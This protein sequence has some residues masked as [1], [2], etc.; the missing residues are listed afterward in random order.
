MKCVICGR[1]KSFETEGRIIDGTWY[2]DILV[3]KELHGKWVCCYRCYRDLVDRAKEGKHDK[4][5]SD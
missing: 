4:V 5:D 2:S 3:P 1:N